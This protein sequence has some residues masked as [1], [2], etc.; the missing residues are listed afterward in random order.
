L[1][2]PFRPHFR[3]WINEGDP[4]A[5]ILE[6]WISTYEDQR[7]PVDAEV[8]VTSEIKIEAVLRYAVTVIAAALTPAAMV[9]VPRP[10]ARLAKT[11]AHLR[12]VL[13][14]AAGV[15]AAIDGSV[16]FDPAMI[17]AAVS[18]L[19][20][21]LTLGRLISLTLCRLPLGLVLLCLRLWTLLGLLALLPMLIFLFLPRFALVLTLLFVL[22]IPR[23]AHSKK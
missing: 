9:V 7:Q 16:G 19:L 5:V 17:G 11:V 8:V 15:H 23:D 13:W 12:L 3:P 6:A 2:P 14:Y 20:P 4:I 10:G 21:S 18:L 22:C 1:I